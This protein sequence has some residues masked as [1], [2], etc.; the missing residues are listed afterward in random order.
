KVMV[1]P[2]TVY[3]ACDLSISMDKSLDQAKKALLSFVRHCDLRTVS[4]GLLSYSDAARVDL[5]A[6]KDDKALRRA[7]D[8]LTIA[9]T[10]YGNNGHPFDELY[11]ELVFTQELRRAVILTDGVWSYQGRA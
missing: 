10:G 3:L 4:I 5:V 2:L 11:N 6:T 1:M 8:Q 7:I 9:R